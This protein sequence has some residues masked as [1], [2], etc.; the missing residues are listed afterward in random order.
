MMNYIWAG[1]IILSVVC[2]I[3]TGRIADVSNSIFTGGTQAIDLS[4]TLLGM[5]ALWG[6]LTAVMQESGLSAVFGKIMKPFVH[7]LFP[8][9]KHQPKATNAIAMNMAA[10]FLGLGNAATPLGLK[11]MEEL[12]RINGG[13]TVA[14]NSMITFVVLNSVSIQL[15]PTTLGMLRSQFGSQKP[16]EI[17]PAVWFVSLI[18]AV[19]GVGLALLFNKR[20][21]DYV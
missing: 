7:L 17:L 21:N 11:A 18:A 16:M 6:G 15:I 2:G 4:L 8:E 13:K 3:A 5:L 1:M 19:V 14:S 12:S 10:N 9:L 20:R